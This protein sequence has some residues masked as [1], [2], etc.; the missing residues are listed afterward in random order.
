MGFTI[1]A[2]DWEPLERWV[3]IHSAI[4]I[5]SSKSTLGCYPY[6]GKNRRFGWLFVFVL[7]G[8]FVCFSVVLLF[9]FV[10]LKIKSHILLSRECSWMRG[11]ST[12]LGKSQD[13]L[14]SRS[15]PPAPPTHC[16]PCRGGWDESSAGREEGADST[17]KH[18]WRV[19][20][21]WGGVA[22]AG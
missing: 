9:V 2:T 5:N 4:M 15:R 7:F 20:C 1:L 10:F 3:I 6:L 19:Q 21:R 11:F 22:R 14:E 12:E 18:T 17:W 8:F 13:I 16:N